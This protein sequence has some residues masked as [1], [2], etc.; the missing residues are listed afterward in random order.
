MDTR[1]TAAMIQVDVFWSFAMGASLATLAGERLKKE[2]SIIVNKYFIYTVCYLSLIFSPSGVYL[3][4]Q[5]TGWETMFF[6]GPEDLHGIFPCLF[7]LT[8]VLLGVIGFVLCAYLVREGND[9]TAHALWTTSYTCMFAI[10]TFGY[11]RFIYAGSLEDWRKG[12]RYYVEDFFTSE[13]FF[14]LLVMSV[15]VLPPL[16]YAMT[17]WPSGPS[18]NQERRSELLQ[19]AVTPYFRV[20]GLVITTFLVLLYGVR[21]LPPQYH[22]LP[23]TW[24]VDRLFA[25]LLGQTIFGALVFVPICLIPIRSTTKSKTQ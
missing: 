10:L 1:L 4:W 3:L 20:T 9:G 18:M 22:V 16:Y 23:P 7:A 11:D 15:F 8:N 2:T 19:D 6:F 12:V 5:H 14:T 17:I 13:V 25:F 24:H 21:R